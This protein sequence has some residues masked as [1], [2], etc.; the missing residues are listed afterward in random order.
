MYYGHAFFGNTNDKNIFTGII[1][2]N[3]L[4]GDKIHTV[5]T[6]ELTINL[7]ENNHIN[8][9]IIP[10]ETYNRRKNLKIPQKFSI[11]TNI[12]LTRLKK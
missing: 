12:A 8:W 2:D 11:P 7:K 9:K 4:L 1:R 3:V 10:I 6:G 5:K